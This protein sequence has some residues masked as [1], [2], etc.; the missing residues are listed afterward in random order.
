MPNCSLLRSKDFY[1]LPYE[2]TC[3]APAMQ[4]NKF[5]GTVECVS[6]GLKIPLD[7]MNLLL[8]GCNLKN[9][10]EVIAICCYTGSDTKLVLNSAKFE[11]KKSKL[12]MEVDKIV[13]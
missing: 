2:I 12:M 9:V 1:S 7:S 8:R 5:D 4:I 10:A 13:I 6:A 3:G 11:P